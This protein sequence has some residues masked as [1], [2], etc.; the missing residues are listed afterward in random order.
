MPPE[1][2]VVEEQ[3]EEDGQNTPDQD[4]PPEIEDSIDEEDQ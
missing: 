2:V 4:Q 3:S 1:V